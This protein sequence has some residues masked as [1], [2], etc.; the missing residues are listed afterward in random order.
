MNGQI[1]RVEKLGYKGKKRER[2]VI[3]TKDELRLLMF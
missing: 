1:S 2:A 3:G